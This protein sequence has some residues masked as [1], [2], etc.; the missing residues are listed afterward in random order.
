MKPACTPRWL[1]FTAALLFAAPACAGGGILIELFPGHGTPRQL[2]VRGR[3]YEEPSLFGGASWALGAFGDLFSHAGEREAVTIRAGAVRVEA[4]TNDRGY[5]HAAL[6]APP[7]APWAGEVRVEAVS[8]RSGAS[9]GAAYVPSSSSTI[10]LISSIDGT[11]ASADRGTPSREGAFRRDD[12][13]AAVP[14][15][16][17]LYAA[18]A[19]DR[20][21]GPRPVCYFSALPDVLSPRVV[22][23]LAMYRFPP[24]PV[25]LAEAAPLGSPPGPSP[26]AVYDHALG[27]IG[28]FLD[29]W[30]EKEFVLFGDGE[31][32]DPAI[33]RCI[34]ARYRARI[35]G[36]YIRRAGGRDPAQERGCPGFV[37]FDSAAEAARDLARKGMITEG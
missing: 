20:A 28:E 22:G 7:G 36:V 26:Q 15:M 35:R 34:A 12:A 29:T 5:F 4:R 9:R 14:G 6:P 11:I 1:G 16:A 2:F 33:Y 30:P 25:M 13:P 19:E 3:V 27:A 21:K 32:E 10:G 17:V 37:F 31:G 18:F 23:F 24:G 8:A